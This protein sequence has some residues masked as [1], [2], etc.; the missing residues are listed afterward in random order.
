MKGGSNDEGTLT[1][2]TPVVH[3]CS[4]TFIIR[5]SDFVIP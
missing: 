3:R 1:T 4:P 2:G 5:H